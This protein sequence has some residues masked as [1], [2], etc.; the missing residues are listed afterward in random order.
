MIM[1]FFDFGF[2]VNCPFRQAYRSS[3]PIESQRFSVLRK[4]KSFRF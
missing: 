2:A 1:P 3:Y 4:E